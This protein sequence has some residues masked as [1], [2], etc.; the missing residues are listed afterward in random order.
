MKISTA[1][2]VAF[3]LDVVYRT[4]RDELAE[5]VPYLPNV[6]SIEG[7]EREV[8]EHKTRLL[9]LWRGNASIPKLARGF[10]KPE[11]LTWDDYAVWDDRTHSCE[12]RSEPHFFSDRTTCTGTTTLIA[13][14]EG[15]RMEIRGDFAIDLKG[16]RGVPRM[17]VGPATKAAETFIVALLAPN[18]ASVSTA[19]TDYLKTRSAR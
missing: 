18:L 9:N 2:R 11:M 5:L 16:M 1:A 7:K 8:E 6:A 4:Y 15:T 3:P 19:L 10:V 17:M 12:W 13:D 14:G